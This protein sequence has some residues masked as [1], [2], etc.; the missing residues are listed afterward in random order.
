M[1]YTNTGEFRHEKKQ[2]TNAVCRT[3]ASAWEQR[4]TVLT[5]GIDEFAWE[6]PATV[7]LTRRTDESC[8]C[9]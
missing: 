3:L 8:S 6:W 7:L 5:C 4:A 9:L 2:Q 1:M